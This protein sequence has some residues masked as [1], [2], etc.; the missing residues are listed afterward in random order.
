MALLTFPANS[1]L[2]PFELAK[3][4]RLFETEFGDG[5]SE[6]IPDGLNHMLLPD[7]ELSWNNIY[8]SEAAAFD[9]F[10]TARGGIEPFYYTLAP[11]EVSAR[12]FKCKKWRTIYKEGVLVDFRATFKEMPP[13][14]GV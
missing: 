11:I 9:S 10:L 7:M 3:S 1:K 5:Y 8:Q 14:F 6:S 12:I 2:S 4:P 13:G